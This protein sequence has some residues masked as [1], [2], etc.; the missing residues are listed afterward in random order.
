MNPTQEPVKFT[1]PVAMA[2]G[3]S[4]DV[5]KA[6][7]AG[8]ELSGQYCFAEPFPHI[9]IDDFLPADLA[10]RIHRGFPAEIGAG[11]KIFESGYAG[12]HKRQVF[13][14]DCDAFNRELFAFFNSAP[15]LQFLEGL[16]CVQKL[17]A[18]P[19]FEGGGFHE[20]FTGGKLGIHA[21]FRVNERLNLQRR[22]N[23]LIYLNKDWQQ[24]WGGELELWDRQMKGKARSVL[25]V[26]NRCVVFS[27]DADSYHGHPDPLRCPEDVSRKSIALY[28]YTASERIYEEVPADSTM[29]RARPGDDASIHAEA[30]RLRFQNYV[31]D[32]LPPAVFRAL[33]RAKESLR[34]G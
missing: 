30:R 19:Y 7:E 6:R 11:D 31:K 29:Y 15:V 8:E 20:I 10:E 9:V 14:G 21:D 1:L 34:K 23:M 22:L 24:A 33:H 27:T 32:W 3:L 2:D 18:D 12:H 26:F 25:P 5:K 16:T 13:P 4:M 17:V 28:Y